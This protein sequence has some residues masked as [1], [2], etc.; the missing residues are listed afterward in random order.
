ME[1]PRFLELFDF[2]IPSVVRGRRDV[3]NVPSQALAL[4]NDP[5]VTGQAGHWA[6][7]LLK[8]RTQTPESRIDTM[9]QTA[10]GRPAELHE[11]KRFVSLA[12]ELAILRQVPRSAILGDRTVWQDVAHSIFNLKEFIYLR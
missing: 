2:P 3:T 10:L 9:F 4:L 5:F 8:A 11:Q 6:E 12:G 7:R 1:G